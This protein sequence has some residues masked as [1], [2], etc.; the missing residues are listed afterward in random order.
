MAKAKNL[1]EMLMGAVVVIDVS[2][3]FRHSSLI[4][5]Y[6]VQLMVLCATGRHVQ[7]MKI[8]TRSFALGALPMYRRKKTKTKSRKSS[9]SGSGDESPDFNKV[10]IECRSL[11]GP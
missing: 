1:N 8:V 10:K 3:L 2:A 7:G 5:F 4:I 9:P 6:N 11:L